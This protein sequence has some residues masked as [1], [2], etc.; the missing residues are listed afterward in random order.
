VRIR[1]AAPSANRGQPGLRE[2]MQPL[3]TVNHDLVS[4]AVQR[5][6][7]AAPEDPTSSELT[8]KQISI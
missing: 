1:T 7:S 8:S 2:L 3:V 4:D 6:G 5:L